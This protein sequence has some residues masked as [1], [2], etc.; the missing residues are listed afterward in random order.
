MSSDQ[1]QKVDDAHVT[2]EYADD[3]NIWGWHHTF[4][5]GGR[6]AGWITAL[7]I[8]SMII[9]N[10][11]GHVED[12]WLAVIGFGMIAVLI[13]DIGKRRKSWRS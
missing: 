3:P 11:T 10:H 9:G 4:G 5:K 8:L 6:A 13:Y 7:I 2:E 1:V 12:L